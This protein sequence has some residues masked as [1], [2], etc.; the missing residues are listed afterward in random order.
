[1]DPVSFVVRCRCMLVY[2]ARVT[3]RDGLGH[4]SL[5]M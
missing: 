3:E 1:M 2:E 5:H 4:K